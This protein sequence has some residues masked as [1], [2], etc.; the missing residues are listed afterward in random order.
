MLEPG[1]CSPPMPSIPP[2]HIPP[3]IVLAGNRW[4]TP[5]QRTAHMCDIHSRQHP[6]TSPS[7][8]TRCCVLQRCQQIC[9]LLP[10][11]RVLLAASTSNVCCSTTR[12]RYRSIHQAYDS[13]AAIS[14]LAWAPKQLVFVCG[15]GEHKHR[16]GHTSTRQP[17]RAVTTKHTLGVTM[18]QSEAAVMYLSPSKDALCI[19]RQDACSS[20]TSVA[21]VWCSQSAVCSARG[22]SQQNTSEHQRC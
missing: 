21:A 16:P 2:P 7:T 3:W 4:S 17:T 6:G 11:T 10:P 9:L 20:N 15:D 19:P 1:L 5:H 8:A 14:I 22:R 18:C 12:H 13:A